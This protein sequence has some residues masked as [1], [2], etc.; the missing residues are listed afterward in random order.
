M[1]LTA[2]WAVSPSPD[3]LMK[4][5]PSRRFLGAPAWLWLLLPFLLV[6][7]VK[8]MGPPGPLS[9]PSEVIQM[10]QG[11][12]LVTKTN[13]SFRFVPF[14]QREGRKPL[15][16]INRTIEQRTSV[17]WP[18]GPLAGSVHLGFY[19][20]TTKFHYSL[21]SQPFVEAG[22]SPPTLET[23]SARELEILRPALVTELNS[24]S[25][26]KHWGDRLGKLLDSDSETTSY[27]CWQNGIILLS[28]LSVVLA[29]FALMIVLSIW[30]LKSPEGANKNQA[31]S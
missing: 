19:K 14:G 4:L 20:R 23:L 2:S 6:V 3:S 17:E 22:G 15:W 26:E 8:L 21:A 12:L 24:R 16:W 31:S 10:W 25:G 7:S 29:V 5:S 13:N 11:G 27:I 18:I 9:E 28:W 1:R 30:P